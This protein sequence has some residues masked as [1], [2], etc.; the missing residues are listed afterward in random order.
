MASAATEATADMTDFHVPT[1]DPQHRRVL[2]TQVLTG[3]RDESLPVTAKADGE[4]L[5]LSRVLWEVEGVPVLAT[6]V[7]TVTGEQDKGHSVAA[8]EDREEL[9]RVWALQE[10]DRAPMA[11]SM[12]VDVLDVGPWRV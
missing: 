10:A 6:R 9:S 7:L 1:R 11:L 2:A 3:E 4:E 5:Y 8:G 12:T